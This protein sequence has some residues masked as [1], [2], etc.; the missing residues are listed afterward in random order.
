MNPLVSVIIPVYNGAA[1]LRECPDCFTA[2]TYR[3]IEVICVDDGS[4][5]ES[6]TILAEYA[7]AH[8]FFRTVRQDNQGAGVARNRGMDEAHG[9]F[10]LFFD[11]DDLCDA[12]VVE[13]GVE[14]AEE[15]EADFVW[16]PYFVLD[17][18]VG[19]PL[20]LEDD[21]P[22]H[23][24]PKV[25]SWRDNPDWLFRSVHNYP[26][27]KLFRRSFVDEHGIRFELLRLTEDLTFAARAAVRAKRIASL[28]EALVTHRQGQPTSLMSNKDDHPFDF[29]E[30]YLW[31]KGF[32]ESEGVFEPLKVA[33]ANWVASGCVYNL[34][35]L[36]RYESFRNVFDELSTGGGLARLGLS[37]LDPAVLQEPSYRTF[38]DCLQR[39]KPEEYLYRRFTENRRAND[40]LMLQGRLDAIRCQEAVAHLRAAHDEAVAGRDAAL[41]ELDRLHG[42]LD[43]Q[44]NAMEQRIGRAICAGPRAIQRKLLASRERDK[45]SER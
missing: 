33:Y 16:L 1:H 21:F 32:L 35:T 39:E 36:N 29:L 19:E 25:F 11:C 15:A 30:A 7:D 17:E 12:T 38:L 44:A 43:A 34:E 8:P 22:I 26:W 37:D 42:E 41:H 6:P 45:T 9:D 23:H 27:N 18:R 2:Q 40:V 20:L 10:L 14:L 31:L 3:P 13:R 4:T 24:F 28:E 5:D